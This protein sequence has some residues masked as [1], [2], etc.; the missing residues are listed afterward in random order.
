VCDPAAPSF[1]F[2]EAGRRFRHTLH[3]REGRARLRSSEVGSGLGNNRRG[4]AGGN[5]AALPTAQTE[6]RCV[7]AWR[8]DA[9]VS[10]GA[11]GSPGIGSVLV[12]CDIDGIGQRDLGK[13]RFFAGSRVCAQAIRREL[14]G[15]ALPTSRQTAP[16]KSAPHAVGTDMR[17]C[18][19]IELVCRVLQLQ[20]GFRWIESR[21]RSVAVV[22]KQLRRFRRNRLGV[23][24]RRIQQSRQRGRFVGAV[25]HETGVVV[26]QRVG[27]QTQC[28]IQPLGPS[29]R[30]VAVVSGTVLRRRRLLRHGHP[31]RPARVSLRDALAH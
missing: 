9:A 28:R 3:W 26:R 13:R 30:V 5:T 25:H 15:K 16:R 17:R 10:I 24:M 31:V 14:R 1:K 4:V 22:A 8:R 7:S 11:R 18:D 20:I 29:N 27:H 12:G 2:A 21:G 19:G 23:G 6:R